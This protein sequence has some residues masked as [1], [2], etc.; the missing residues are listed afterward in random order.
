M[1]RFAAG[2]EEPQR[3]HLLRWSLGHRRRG[4][5]P[6]HL[7]FVVTLVRTS[8]GIDVDGITE[9]TLA[10]APHPPP[11]QELL[12]AFLPPLLLPVVLLAGCSL[13]ATTR[14]ARYE[15]LRLTPA[16]LLLPPA[17][18]SLVRRWLGLHARLKAPPP[19]SPS[20]RRRPPRRRTTTFLR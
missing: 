9:R 11:G 5:L 18:S 3:G 20:L 4:P 19:R 10:V 13:Q 14:P 2:R 1:G 8:Q 6:R 15:E 16:G 7:I 17:A 12:V